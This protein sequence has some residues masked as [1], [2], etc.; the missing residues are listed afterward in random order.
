MCIHNHVALGKNAG[1]S[2]LWCGLIAGGIGAYNGG[3]YGGTLG[4]SAGSFL[5]KVN[6]ND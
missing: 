4:E 2:L 5:Y 3:K 6:I 1:T